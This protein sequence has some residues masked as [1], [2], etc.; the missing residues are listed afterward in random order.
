MTIFVSY[1]LSLGTVGAGVG[2]VIGL[3][4]VAKIN[5]IAYFLERLTGRE[6]FDPTVYY[7]QTIPTIV[8]PLTV[9][10]IVIGAISIAVL[11][12]VLPALRAARLH[13]VEALRYE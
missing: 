1:G 12:S 3:I 2:M 6:L 4:F 9:A 5:T 11:A 8:R 13:P 10:W 7:F